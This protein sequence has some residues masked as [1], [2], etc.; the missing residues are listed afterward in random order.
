MCD[1]FLH[2]FMFLITFF[3]LP[4]L[5]MHYTLDSGAER[6][7]SNVSRKFSEFRTQQVN[8]EEYVISP[9]SISKIWDPAFP[10]PTMFSIDNITSSLSN[11]TDNTES[12]V[13]KVW[14][15]K[16]IHIF[17]FSLAIVFQSFV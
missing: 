3:S 13:M 2:Q 7:L 8:L 9:S 11:F 17:Q 12:E 16:G 6:H 15:K 5:G 1:F 10:H 14:R 4:S